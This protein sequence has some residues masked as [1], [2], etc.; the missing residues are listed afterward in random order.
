[1]NPSL[2]KNLDFANRGLK[3]DQF[4]YTAEICKNILH[5]QPDCIEARKLL[6][7]VSKHIYEHKTWIGK[8]LAQATS[9]VYLLLGAIFC[10]GNKLKMIEQGLCFYPKGKIGLIL[11][12]QAA[13][14]EDLLE[15]LLFAYEEMSL[16]FPKEDRFALAL[17]N[18]HI[19]MG[20]YQK[21]LE[22]GRQLLE[23]DASNNEAMDLVEQAVL[24]QIQFQGNLAEK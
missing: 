19:S 24:M 4:I 13:L 8:L 9:I 18:V 20:N 2:Q 10:K 7:T 12:A 5:D 11:L 3:E 16:L 15:I 6:Q 22:I 14:D 23:K 1:M 17:G 21:S